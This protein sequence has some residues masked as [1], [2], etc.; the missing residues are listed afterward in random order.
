MNIYLK[1][2]KYIYILHVNAWLTG[3]F[4]IQIQMQ[5]SVGSRSEEY[6]DNGSVFRIFAGARGRW[7]KQVQNEV[8]KY[9]KS[10]KIQVSKSFKHKPS[11]TCN[12]GTLYTPRFPFFQGRKLS[13]KWFLKVY[14]KMPKRKANGFCGFV[15][16]ENVR[17]RVTTKWVKD[18]T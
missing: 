15:E 17:L 10:I 2:S 4:G 3:S 9:P 12:T 18:L 1:L 13:T 6:Q 7:P 11:Q 14:Y 5:N 8:Q 16:V